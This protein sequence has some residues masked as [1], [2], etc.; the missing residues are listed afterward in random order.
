MVRSIIDL[1][2]Q[3]NKTYEFKFR[4]GSQYLIDEKYPTVMNT[5]GT[6][7]NFIIVYEKFIS[8]ETPSTKNAPLLGKKVSSMSQRSQHSNGRAFRWRKVT[9]SLDLP[10]ERVEGHSM[11][12]VGEYIYIFGGTGAPTKA[13]PGISSTTRCSRSTPSFRRCSSR[14]SCPTAAPSIS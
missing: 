10:Y 8:V 9:C 13:S 7:N 12:S 5:F 4:H 14:S 11:C 2:L 3:V 6:L 1:D